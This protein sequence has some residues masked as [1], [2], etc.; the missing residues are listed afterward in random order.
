MRTQV[1]ASLAVLAAA[2][3]P[4]RAAGADPLQPGIEVEYHNGWM[5]V[6]LE[7]SYAGSYYRVWR[8]DEPAGE[9]NALHAQYTLCTGDCSVLMQDALA[10]RTYSF[11]FDLLVG[12]EFVSYGPFLVTVPEAPAA[13]RMVPNP[14]RGEARIELTLPG[15]RRAD[16]PLETTLQVVDA[17]GRFVKTL[18]QGPVERG[19]TAI[20]WDRRGKRGETLTSGV[21]FLRLRTPLGQRLER[22][23]LLGR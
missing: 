19:T 4:P 18:H 14:A 15:D 7:G 5:R 22:V 12:Q 8:A 9:F 1:L 20:A 21:Y 16:E 23:V 10:G 3:V 17:R 13:V 6:T 2:L 11:R